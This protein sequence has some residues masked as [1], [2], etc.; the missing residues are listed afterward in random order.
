MGATV[1]QIQ[2]KLGLEYQKGPYSWGIN[3]AVF[4]HKLGK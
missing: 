2:G 4:E 3:G 1:C